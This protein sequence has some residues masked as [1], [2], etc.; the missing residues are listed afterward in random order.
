MRNVRAYKFVPAV[1]AYVA[2]T[3]VGHSIAHPPAV[4]SAP[5][6]T[7]RCVRS[8]RLIAALCDLAV[9]SAS[10]DDFIGRRSRSRTQAYRDRTRQLLNPTWNRHRCLQCV[11]KLFYCIKSLL[12]QY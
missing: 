11:V 3:A 7:R 10:V 1:R 5:L 8:R 6:R 2:A 9:T 12:L 4:L